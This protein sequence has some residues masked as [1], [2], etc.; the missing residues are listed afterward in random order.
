[1]LPQMTKSP[2]WCIRRRLAVKQ[3]YH[4][5]VLPV[6]SANSQC[7]TY[8][9]VN[10]TRLPTLKLLITFIRNGVTSSYRGPNSN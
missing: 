1:M 8:H 9:C 3:L 6:P 7:C 2:S 10:Q 5:H 4:V